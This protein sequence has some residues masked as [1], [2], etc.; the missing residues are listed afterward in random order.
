MTVAVSAA[1]LAVL[2]KAGADGT[3]VQ[4]WNFGS[5]QNPALSDKGAVALVSPGQFA[6]GWLESHPALAGGQ[7]GY[8]DLGQNGTINISAASAGSTV[9]KVTVKVTQWWDGGIYDD[10][11]SAAVPS[12]HVTLANTA[13]LSLG[14]LGGWVTDESEWDA[15]AGASISSIQLASGKNGSIVDS[16]VVESVVSV[17]APP[18]LTITAL[19][20][21]Q[22][23]LSWPA[24]FSSMIVESTDDLSGAQNWSKVDGTVSV[25]QSTCTLTTS[26][27]GPARFYR[28]KQP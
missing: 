15:N 17:A 8:W 6:S 28:L 21:G 20:N 9:Q 13:A 24:S 22:L 18:Q 7:G 12:A 3:V 25:G 5:G 16:V 23:Q 19:G 11:V 27:D 1:V 2:P 14:A 10:L 26:A 4:T